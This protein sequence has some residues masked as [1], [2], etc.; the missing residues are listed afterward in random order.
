MC[1]DDV[2]TLS[3]I[4]PAISNQAKTVEI[5]EMTF[6]PATACDTPLWLKEYQVL[7]FLAAVDIRGASRNA[8]IWQTLFPKG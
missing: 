2:I 4:C 8:V 6:G 7:V 5:V 3:R 1:V